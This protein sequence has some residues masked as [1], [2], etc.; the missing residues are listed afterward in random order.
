MLELMILTIYKSKQAD[1]RTWKTA[2]T[3]GVGHLDFIQ[4]YKILLAYR[5]NHPVE[6][7]NR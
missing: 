6:H 3:E 2:G 7:R 4:S 5:H 1:K